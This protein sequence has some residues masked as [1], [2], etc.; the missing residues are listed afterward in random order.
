LIISI[1][2]TVS[3]LVLTENF[4]DSLGLARRLRKRTAIGLGQFDI[5]ASRLVTRIAKID[6]EWAEGWDFSTLTLA[7]RQDLMRIRCTVLAQKTVDCFFI[8]IG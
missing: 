1:S 7:S 8:Y 4:G 3:L 5:Q 2:S 6:N